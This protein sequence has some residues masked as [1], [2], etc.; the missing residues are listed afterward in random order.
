MYWRT[1]TCMSCTVG[2]IASHVLTLDGTGEHRILPRTT[3]SGMARW[4]PQSHPWTR[5][6]GSVVL[7]SYVCDTVGWPA[8]HYMHALSW[9]RPINSSYFCGKRNLTQV[10]ARHFSFH[11][12]TESS[13]NF[14]LHAH[15]YVLGVVL[16]LPWWP[17]VVSLHLGC[18]LLLQQASVVLPSAWDASV[19]TAET[20]CSL[21]V[22]KAKKQ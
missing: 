7:A 14:D 18:T 15:A 5:S 12:S 17:C 21:V 9:Q 2:P 3:Y 19:L 11:Y 1:E 6:S 20:T 10:N 22:E 4:H 13:T 16:F 8:D